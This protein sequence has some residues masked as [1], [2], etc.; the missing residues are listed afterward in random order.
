MPKLE[1]TH[2]GITIT[3]EWDGTGDDFWED[4][5]AL[6][7]GKTCEFNSIDDAIDYINEY[8][9]VNTDDEREEYALEHRL[10]K[11]ELV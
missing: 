5:S 8:F 11:W 4:I 10:R 2:H 1:L 7:D 9:D 6:I 3:Q